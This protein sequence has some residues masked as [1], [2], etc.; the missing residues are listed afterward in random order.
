VIAV[1]Y[2][3]RVNVLQGAPLVA[4]GPFARA[5]WFQLLTEA[6]CKFPL[7]AVARDDAQLAALPLMRQDGQLQPLTN[8]YS[9][10]WRP[11]IGAGTQ[12]LPLLTALARRLKDQT[13]RLVLQALPGED[14]SADL[15]QQAFRAAGWITLRS[16]CDSNHV[17]PVGGRDYAAYLA[18]LPGKIRTSLKRKAGRVEVQLYTDFQ[19]D[20]W[21]IYEDIY[22][23]S[24]KPA[25]GNPALLRRFV[26]AEGAAGRLRMA[27]ARH[28]GSPVAAQFWTVESGTAYIHKLAH[29]EEAKPLSAGTILTA[30][31][32]EQV[33]D[34]DHVSLVDFGTGNDSYKADWMEEVRPRYRLECI[35]PARPAQWPRLARSLAGKLATRLRAG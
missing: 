1:S 7:I 34:R 9:F 11:L 12:P 16:I 13:G 5:E 17:L 33:L 2:H 29:I 3:D 28:Q 25:E 30:A 14:G 31:L 8:W 21:Y 15:V 6:D 20:A 10:T 23:R 19:D 35:N 18:G 22:N 26:Q 27:I 32:F 4:A 24:W